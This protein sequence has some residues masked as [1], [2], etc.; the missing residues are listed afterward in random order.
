MIPNCNVLLRLSTPVPPEVLERHFREL[1]QR[2][3]FAFS[4]KQ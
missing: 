1:E 3:G 2:T 4:V